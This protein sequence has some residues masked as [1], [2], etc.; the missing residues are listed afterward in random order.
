MLLGLLGAIGASLCYG[1]AS[2]L[3]AMAARR[4]ASAAGLDP[5]LFLRLIRSWRYLLGLGLDGLAFVLSIAALRTLPL[6][7]VQSIVA[8]FLAVTAVLGAFVFKVPLRRADKLGVV[9]VVAGLIL[10]GLS[11]APDG[12]ARVGSGTLWGV[13][14]AALVLAVLAFPLARVPGSAGAAALGGVAGCAFGVVAIAA[15]VLP[16]H[17]SLR[18]VSNP[19]VYALVVAAVVALLTYS[20]ALQRGSV[21]LA[22]APLVIAETVGP[23]LV[24]LVALHDHPRP[25]LGALAAVGFVVAVGGAISLARHGEVVDPTENP[26]DT[27]ATGSL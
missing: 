13:L 9:V 23:A 25:G 8:S 7:A 20:T 24:G 5:R 22:T 14:V 10:V 18:L 1:V 15:R 26:K 12:P 3:Q 27:F 17:L 4:T 16:P 6:F 11:A 19:A 21:V 2:V